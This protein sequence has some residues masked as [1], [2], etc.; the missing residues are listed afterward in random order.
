MAA[1]MAA[2]SVNLR[3]FSSVL[4][5]LTEF[6]SRKTIQLHWIIALAEKKYYRQIFFFK[7]FKMASKM[8]AKSLN[9]STFDAFQSILTGFFNGD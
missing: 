1:N 9:L 7:K 4:L 5:M 3:N 8:A 6:F 2:E